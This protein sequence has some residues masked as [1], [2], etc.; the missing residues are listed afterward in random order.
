ML[1]HRGGTESDLTVSRLAPSPQASPL[2]PAFEGKRRPRGPVVLRLQPRWGRR[3]PARGGQG[4]DALYHQSARW[5]RARRSEVCFRPKAAFVQAVLLGSEHSVS[6]SLHL[7]VPWCFRGATTW[8]CTSL[9]PGAEEAKGKAM[10]PTRARSRPPAADIRIPLL[11]G[12]PYN[13]R[14]QTGAGGQV[15]T[16]VA[17]CRPPASACMPLVTGSSALTLLAGP[18]LTP[19]S[20]TCL[21]HLSS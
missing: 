19:P 10:S 8:A 6:M 20:Q 5:G 13:S 1:N 18:A 15:D 7:P 2:T 17:L 4:R 12:F 21:C 11:S 14:S 3:L 16:R 9:L